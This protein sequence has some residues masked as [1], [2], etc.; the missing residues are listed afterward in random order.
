MIASGFR[1]SD[2]VALVRTIPALLV[3]WVMPP[4][5]TASPPVEKVE[6]AAALS[7]TGDF[8]PFGSGSLQG[9]QF[10]VEEANAGNAGPRIDLK[11][12]DDQSTPGGAREAAS[13]V[14]AS[15]AVLVLGPS[16]TVTSLAAG[17]VYAEAGLPS[18]ATS[19]TSD[20][21][22]D[23][24]TTFRLVFK[25]SEQ[26][27][28][29]A[30]YLQRVLGRRRAA[31]LV[32]DD[33]Y[34][35]TLEKGFRDTAARIGLEATSF[36]FKKGDDLE[37][38]AETIAPQVAGVPVILSMLDPEGARILPVL[39]RHGAK[40]PFFGG[41]AFGV[42][43]FA[44]QL[45][46]LP[47]EKE[48]PGFFSEGLYGITPMLL[49]SAN[50]EILSFAERFNQRFGHN[51]D[52]IAIAGYDAAV[53]AI[54]TVRG[55]G[56]AADVR[57]KRAAAL[58]HLLTLT[59]V[60]LAPPGLLGPLLFDSER[61]RQTAVRVGRFTHGRF[62]SAPL[63][64]VPVL[65]P[66][67]AELESGA[68]FEIR[69]GRYG[70]LQQIIYSGLYLNEIMWIDQSH[71]TFGADFYVWL[72]FAKNSGPE[73]A[74]PNEIKFPDLSNSN[75][76]FD[77]EHPVEQQDLPDGTCYRLWRVQ[78]EFRN[79]F[80]LRRYPFDRQKLMLRFFNARAASDRIVYAIDRSALFD[81]SGTRAGFSQDA[82][83]GLS[84]WRFLAAHHQRETFVA[85]STLGDPRR[86]A[87]EEF[88]ELS[89]YAASFDLQ[90]RSLTTLTKN[91][92]PLWLMTCILYASLHFPS[93]LV[94]P[95]IGVAM[96][97]VL[98]GM[99]LLNL[100]NSQLGS[101]GYTVAV[102]YAF[103]VY[104]ALG[105]LHIV[106]VLFSEHLR[107]TGHPVAAKRSDIWARLIFLGAVAG[108]ILVASLYP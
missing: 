30:T 81:A 43:S 95:K 53:L 74:D 22:T 5:A 72:R 59:D 73:A 63:Q 92:L 96:T 40:G 28:M 36:V 50:S 9:I 20:L 94:Q 83:R 10:A 69:P 102:E 46:R 14:V 35:R 85:R 4:A 99:V 56:N 101:I 24:P 71:F 58:Q 18:L 70:R 51:P 45:V 17:P 31:V 106:S 82:F 7:V 52:W 44:A 77:R 93:V 23:N 87:A 2:L 13:R 15:S 25:N 1:I 97:A 84:Q 86:T 38:M 27:E 48:H 29:L 32:M 75:G 12:Y 68:V 3:W 6:I 55:M 88:R 21:I 105:L 67:A 108:L 79:N 80:D 66:H 16:N 42:E 41:D 60:S 39:R 33:G 62:E 54:E 65:H 98:T 78:A 107:E 61:S 37:Q 76:R 49:D 103:Y 8:T 91:L 90:R 34:G 11:I 57:A 104:F 47:E 89:G 19:A 64:I 26:G 100:V